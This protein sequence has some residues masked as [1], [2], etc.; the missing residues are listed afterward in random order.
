MYTF[1]GGGGCRTKNSYDRLDRVSLHTRL[2]YP[3]PL[4]DKVLRV[5]T[6]QNSFRHKEG[7]VG[8]KK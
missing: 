1:L 3:C 7:D 6:L 2:S 5:M 8:R 4:R